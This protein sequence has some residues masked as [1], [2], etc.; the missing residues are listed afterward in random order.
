M[1]KAIFIFFLLASLAP[2]LL[3]QHEPAITGRLGEYFEATKVKDWQKVVDMVYPKLF[4]L[5]EKKEMVQMFQDME[6]NGMEFQMGDFAV[7]GISAVMDHEGERFALV[8]YT[9]QMNIRFTSQA[10]REPEMVDMLRQNFVLTYGAENVR[11]NPGDNSFDV[12]AE[13]TMFAISEE[14]EDNWAFME[15]DS[16]NEALIG[17]IIPDAVKEKLLHK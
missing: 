17:V 1:K 13:K 15:S 12:R 11:Y 7:K 9:A 2:A 10:Y 16:A 4:T 8:D 3:A 6:G 5:V 14:G